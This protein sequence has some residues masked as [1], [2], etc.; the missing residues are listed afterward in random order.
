MIGKVTGAMSRTK[1]ALA[2]TFVAAT[3]QLAYR[4][5]KDILYGPFSIELGV[6]L[7]FAFMKVAAL[8]VLGLLFAREL[9][10]DAPQNTTLRKA[11]KYLFLMLLGCLAL[12]FYLL[13]GLRLIRSE[14]FIAQFG[15]GMPQ[16]IVI[17]TMIIMLLAAF[18]PLYHR[19]YH[20]LATI[21]NAKAKD[22]DML[23]KNK[24]ANGQFLTLFSKKLA[25]LYLPLFGVHIVIVKFLLNDSLV[26]ISYVADGIVTCALALAMGY[27]IAAAHREL[28]ANGRIA[29][30]AAMS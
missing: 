23:R 6:F 3:L 29:S 19:Q 15:S 17:V 24:T 18:A 14:S 9:Y 7:C 25:Y 12:A 21:I 16:A 28:S 13:L 5:G 27:A 10:S 30:P 2:V 20:D 11:N 26:L 4:P 22:I 8:A 1:I